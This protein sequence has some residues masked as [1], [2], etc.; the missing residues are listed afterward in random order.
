MEIKDNI[1]IISRLD[2]IK[3]EL[4]YIKENM[5]ERDEIITNDEF[6]A[7]QKS[8]NKNN[9]ISIEEVEKELGL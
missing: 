5:I 9:L 6:E 2:S 8:F 3:V 7:Y 1:A 4:D